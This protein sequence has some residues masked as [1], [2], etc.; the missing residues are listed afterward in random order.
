MPPVTYLD[1]AIAVLKA[2]GRPMTVRE[3]TEEAIARG[4]ITPAGKTP[5]ASMSAALYTHLRND[6]HSEV[7]RL[8][9]AGTHRA[10]R[11]SVQWTLRSGGR[12]RTA[13]Q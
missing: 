7:V 10:V 2:V 5:E 3:I 6:P 8:F 13:S 1:A 4:L 12:A 9:L 11:G